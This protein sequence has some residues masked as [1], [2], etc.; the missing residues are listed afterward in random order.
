[1]NRLTEQFAAAGLLAR[2]SPGRAGQGRRRGRLQGGDD[3]AVRRRL[4]RPQLRCDRLGLLLRCVEEALH[5]LVLVLRRDDLRQLHHARE[6]QASI[7][8]WLDDLWEA[9]DELGS[10]LPVEGGALGK[11]E[12]SMEEVEAARIPELEPASVVVELCERDEKIRQ[13]VVLAPGQ[14]GEAVLEGSRV[15]HD[16][17]CLTRFRALPARTRLRSGETRRARG[18]DQPR[19]TSARNGRPEASR[20][21]PSRAA[22]GR[23]ARRAKIRVE[24]G[25]PCHPSG[26]YG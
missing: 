25:S 6:A 12:L 2:R 8:E 14:L 20:Q 4:R 9:L 18:R 24:R 26:D 19:A 7:P 1:M 21:T 22:E 5:D 13:G 17:E 3:V 15:V 10:G 23:G 11:P 16:G